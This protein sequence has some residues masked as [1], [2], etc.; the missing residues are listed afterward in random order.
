MRPE[1]SF[2]RRVIVIYFASSCLLLLS[3]A[4]CAIIPPFRPIAEGLILATGG[5]V[6]F[7]VILLFLS[8]IVALFD[9]ILCR[10]RR[11]R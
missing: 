5:F 2:L 4:F 9:W 10:V 6:G 11:D 8:A 7:A 1:M 3:A